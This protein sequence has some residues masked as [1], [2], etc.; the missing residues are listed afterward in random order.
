MSDRGGSFLVGFV[1]GAAVGALATLLLTPYSGEE[2][3]DQIKE[4]GIELKTQAT[5]V[6]EEARSQAQQVQDRG[7]IV[8][9]EN[10][11]R[12]QEAVQAAQAKLEKAGAEP[13]EAA[14][15]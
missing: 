8:L 6:A 5:Q 1:V 13:T 11:R 2:I 7:R 15:A 10:V 4:K 9:S 12:A 14:P 3:R